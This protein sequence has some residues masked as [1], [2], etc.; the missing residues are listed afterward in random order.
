MSAGSLIA[1]KGKFLHK[2]HE[3]LSDLSRYAYAWHLLDKNSKF[4]PDNWLKRASLP[5]FIENEI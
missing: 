2:S 3:N 5:E 1:F 4:S